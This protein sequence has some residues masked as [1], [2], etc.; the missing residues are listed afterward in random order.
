MP[1]ALV[2]DT[3]IALDLLVFMDSRCEPLRHALHE[4]RVHWLATDPMRDELARVLAYPAIAPRL[5]QG[6]QAVLHAFD[7][8]VRRVEPGAAA[9]VRCRDPDDQMFI[10]LAFARR[11]ALV[12]RDRA[13]LALRK[14]LA[15]WSIPVHPNWP[16]SRP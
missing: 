7:R 9:P 5:R 6:A 2:L 12:S 14:R 1:E 16:P 11:A 15:A 3:H 8:Q 4:E 10:D 13:V